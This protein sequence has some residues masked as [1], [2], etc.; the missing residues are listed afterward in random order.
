METEFKEIKSLAQGY[1]ERDKGGTKPNSYFLNLEAFHL[2]AHNIY[3]QFMHAGEW[4]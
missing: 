4:Q 1:T 2:D 3:F